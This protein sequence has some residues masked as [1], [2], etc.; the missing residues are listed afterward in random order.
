MGGGSAPLPS[1]Q[2]LGRRHLSPGLQALG[3]KYV[4]GQVSTQRG[5]I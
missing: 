3:G 5:G 1:E 4:V 2:G